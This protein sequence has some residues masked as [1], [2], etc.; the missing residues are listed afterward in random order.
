MIVPAPQQISKEDLV[1]VLPEGWQN[2]AKKPHHHLVLFET[3]LPTITI[4]F[5]GH[6]H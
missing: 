2:L 3:Q 4:P 1:P 6:I 5:L